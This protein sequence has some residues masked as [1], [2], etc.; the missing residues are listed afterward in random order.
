MR[1]I[2]LQNE[3]QVQHR[4]LSVASSVPPGW[5][6]LQGWPDHLQIALLRSCATGLSLSVHVRNLCGMVQGHSSVRIRS[7]R[8]VLNQLFR[9]GTIRNHHDRNGRFGP[10]KKPHLL[11]QTDLPRRQ[12][13]SRR[14]RNQTKANNLPRNHL[15]P[16]PKNQ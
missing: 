3:Q 15:H 6:N 8:P 5:Q 10:P 13:W 14:K 12:K 1:K 11:Q 9:P 4:I 16:H 2:A 7:D